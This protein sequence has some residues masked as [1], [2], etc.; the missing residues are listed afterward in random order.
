MSVYRTTGPLVLI[1]Q[2]EVAKLADT[3]FPELILQFPDLGIDMQLVCMLSCLCL[4]NDY[5]LVKPQSI[6]SNLTLMK[7]GCI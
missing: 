3:N 2:N 7:F 4:I 6:E 5:A 1:F